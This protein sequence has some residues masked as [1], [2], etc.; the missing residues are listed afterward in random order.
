VGRWFFVPPTCSHH[1][2][3]CTRAL[4]DDGAKA[5]VICTRRERPWQTQSL[6]HLSVEPDPS[7]SEAQ[8]TS[9]PPSSWP[10]WSTASRF[11][12]PRT[13]F[14]CCASEALDNR[15]Q[16]TAFESHSGRSTFA[17]GT[18]L[19]PVKRTR[20]LMLGTER[21]LSVPQQT[22]LSTSSLIQAFLFRPQQLVHRKRPVDAMGKATR[23]WRPRRWSLIDGVPRCP[24]QTI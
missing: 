23:K 4:L 3:R 11:I 21:R 10:A 9:A 16:R 18:G 7:M 8:R 24:S 17:A 20:W 15:Q 14:A 1:D 19:R 22:A 12:I 5:V 13:D 6:P 2:D